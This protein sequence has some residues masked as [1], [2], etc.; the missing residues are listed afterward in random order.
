MRIDKKKKN[1]SIK[2]QHVMSSNNKAYNVV[3]TV[4][5]V[6][7]SK[8]GIM[9]EKK[10]K[11]EYIKDKILLDIKQGVYLKD[12]KIPSESEFCKEY[13][14]SRITVR[15]ALDELVAQG[16]LY[17]LQGIGTFVNN[18]ISTSTTKKIVLVLPLFCEGFSSG[19]IA[20]VMRGIE[21]ILI[22]EGYSLISI[23]EPRNEAEISR[24]IQNVIDAQASGLIYTF[25]FSQNLQSHLAKLNIPIV[26]LDAEPKNNMFDAVVGEDYESAY[27][28]TKLLINEGYTKIGFYSQWNAEYSTSRL[29]CNGVMDALKDNGLE[30]E[31]RFI[32]I[33]KV[34]P[35]Y[36]SHDAVSHFDIVSD[37]K[38]YCCIVI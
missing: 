10:S 1:G 32:L 25:Y 17:R 27:R 16:I 23:M 3:V 7:V 28:A 30:H 31:D 24:F 6:V 35:L 33:Q 9:G 8:V 38:N 5:N 15:R 11:Y 13:N 34:N 4:I 36:F 37:V 26:F 12:D 18:A 29:R 20:G 19:L 14:T 2:K 21:S 22:V